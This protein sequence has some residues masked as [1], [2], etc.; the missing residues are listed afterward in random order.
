MDEKRSTALTEARFESL[1]REYGRFLRAVIVRVCPRNMGIQI[2]DVEQ[3]A[4]I[5]FWK[6]LQSEREIDNPASYLYRIAVNAAI[7]ATRRVVAR[8][9][10]QLR[11]EAEAEEAE[12]RPGFPLETSPEQA[13]DRIA[14]RHQILQR[15]EAAIGALAEKRRI[16]VELHLQGMSTREIA[17]LT[18]WSEPKARNLLYR[19]LSE[20][21][22]ALRE[23]GIEYE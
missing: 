23:Q 2:A 20:L 12:P 8:H 13:P 1:V 18:S 6:A 4:R 22:R 7:D 14:A 9:E 5:R 19:G 15:V 17:E 11:T 10:E 16:A 21:R 3:E